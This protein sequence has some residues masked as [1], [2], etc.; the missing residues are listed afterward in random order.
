MRSVRSIAL[1]L[2]LGLFFSTVAHAQQDSLSQAFNASTDPAVRLNIAKQLFGKY[3]YSQ[4]DTAIY[5]AEQIVLI[6]AATEN[7]KDD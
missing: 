4:V 5:Y 6:A 2:F 1:A 7:A 3:V